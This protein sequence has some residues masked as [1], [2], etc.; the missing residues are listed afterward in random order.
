[1]EYS[2]K[3]GGRGSHG[4]YADAREDD[5][6]GDGGGGEASGRVSFGA[7]VDPEEDDVGANPKED[8]VSCSDRGN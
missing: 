4:A 5:A 7:D 2:G 3:N 6:R 1:M 8:D